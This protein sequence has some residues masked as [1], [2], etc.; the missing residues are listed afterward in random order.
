MKAV[1]W[2]AGGLSWRLTLSYIL[3]TLVAAFT[4][5][6][7]VTL[8]STIQDLQRAS[9]SPDLILAKGAAVHPEN[10]LD[11]PHLNEEALRYWVAIPL[12]D[13]FSN[14]QINVSLIAVLD[15]NG[16]E[17]SVTA[18]STTQ[19]LSKGT[20]QCTV[21]AASKAKSILALPQAHAIIA[22][23]L[24]S[25]RDAAVSTYRLPTG[26]T[27]FV[28]PVIGNRKQVVS[29]LV[30]VVTGAVSVE[31]PT[32]NPLVHFL[33]AMWDHLPADGA[34]FILLAITAGTITGLLI[35]RNLAQR[36]LRIMEAANTWS[37]GEFQTI[38]KDTSSDEVGQLTRNLNGMVEQLQLLLTSWQ[39]LAI[40]EER[41]RL[42]RELHDSVK[43]NVFTNELLVRAARKVLSRDP[44]KAQL[45]LQEAEELCEQTQLELIELIQ[46][47]RPAALAEKGLAPV[48]R[49][50]LTTWSRRTGIAF[51]LHMQQKY[52]VQPGIEA[53][54]F[55]IFQEALTNSARHSSARCVRV[56]LVS[57][58]DCFSLIVQDDGKGF[59]I[60]QVPEKGIG[61]TSMRER[62]EMLAGKLTI[63][64]SAQGTVVNARVPLQQGYVK[65]VAGLTEVKDA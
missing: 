50:Y 13:E 43:Q 41:N 65:D 59:E 28:Q 4:I 23:T 15:R 40:V 18:C 17:V 26:E 64:S 45:Y 1:F 63:T 44:E 61:L 47:L 21:M 36:L 29:V 52:P 51:E 25:Q 48:M 6:F 49:D 62:I 56:V 55:R 7:V 27:L 32:G 5:V 58:D 60:S 12:F 24:I 9:V 35:S 30:A 31:R 53:A 39:K 46:A 8:V 14:E 37:K 54:F 19:F 20:Q 57:N 2:R 3:V 33:A 34:F 10:Y 16:Q 22:T 38:L 11:Q 42:A